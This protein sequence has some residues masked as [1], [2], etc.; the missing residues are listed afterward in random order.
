MRMEL[1][2]KVFGI[3]F[4]FMFLLNIGCVFAET[5]TKKGSEVKN[6]VSV[7]KDGFDLVTGTIDKLFG[8]PPLLHG[9]LAGGFSAFN[10]YSKLGEKVKVQ[11]ERDQVNISY[12]K[13]DYSSKLDYEDLNVNF[14]PDSDSRDIVLTDKNVLDLTYLETVPLSEY[15]N[16]ESPKVRVADLTESIDIKDSEDSTISGQLRSVLFE[17]KDET[18][19]NSF[20]FSISTDWISAIFADLND[21]SA[22][23]FKDRFNLPFSILTSLSLSCA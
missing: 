5:T 18:I 2:K 15:Y 17:D 21:F 16:T 7:I 12:N 22:K 4:V 20:E 9:L 19:S 6:Y 14:N 3:I 1:N 13:D 10:T 8:G 11:L 23:G